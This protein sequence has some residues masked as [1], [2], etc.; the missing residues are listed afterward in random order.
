MPLILFAIVLSLYLYNFLQNKVNDFFNSRL[1]ATTQSI[2]DNIGVRH[3]KL[4]VDLPSF[5]ID[6][7][8]SHEK[9]FVY[10]SVEDDTGRILVGH[11]G[12]F[13][14]RRMGELQT[15]FYDLMYENVFLKAI[16]YKTTIHSHGKDLSAYITVAESMEERDENIHDMLSIL[17]TILVIVTFFILLIM[18]IALKEGL[19]PLNS[20]KKMIQRRHRHDLE[21]LQFNAP[22]EL[23]DVVES[24]NILLERSR[25]T[26]EYIEQF[27]SDVSHQ[28][29]TPIAELKMELEMEYKKDDKNFITFN[30]ILD[31]MSHITEQLLLHAKTNANTI[32]IKHFEPL[33]LN[34]FCK[35]YSQKTAIRVFE[36]GFDYS[37]ENLDESITI[38]SDPILLA[39]LLDNLINNAM[40]YAVDSNNQP[41]GTIYLMLE[42]H[43]ENIWLSVKDEGSGLDEKH[44]EQIF[45]RYYR[46]DSKKQGSGLGLSIVKQIAGLHGAKVKAVNEGG[47]KISVIFP[48]QTST[49]KR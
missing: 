37:F 36:R 22:K 20:L 5:S 31:N 9:G 42:R 40:H 6:F 35:K 1:F 49:H 16:S 14:K 41:I 48:Y 46:A 11:K 2:E 45:D 33:E 38:N 17:L 15:R 27:N 19:S 30:R 7:L 4:F 26:I 13:D 34:T 21:P 8:S 12:L 23:E 29:R 39:S 24:I 43:G 47:L 10:Y 32:N 3:G 25:N 44:L 28:L 18:F